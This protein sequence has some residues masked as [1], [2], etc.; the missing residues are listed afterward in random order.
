MKK[1][2]RKCFGKRTGKVLALSWFLFVLA[3]ILDSALRWTNFLVGLSGSFITGILATIIWSAL[4]LL[5]LIFSFLLGK[6]F[7]RSSWPNLLLLAP[8]L[9]AIWI[10]FSGGLR[11]RLDP[12]HRFHSLTSE[13]LPPH[14][15]KRHFTSGG[16]FID[17]SDFYY[18]ETESSE[19]KALIQKLGLNSS[20]AFLRTNRPSSDTEFKPNY[21]G[22]NTLQF[23]SSPDLLEDWPDYRKWDVPQLFI[24]THENEKIGNPIIQLV[25][26]EEMRKIYLFIGTY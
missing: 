10:L 22:A 18:L 25:T 23:L 3:L 17:I 6:K 16:G 7:P 1:W 12:N 5:P 4:I 19:T 13:N 26:D 14:S 15:C 9:L 24:K 2:W 20:P 21:F 8:C 11:S